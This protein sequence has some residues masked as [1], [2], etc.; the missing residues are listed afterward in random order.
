M[1]NISDRE[2][3]D[4]FKNESSRNN[5]FSQ[6]VT[7]Y[8]EKI[9]WHI[10]RMIIDHEDSNDVL[11][12]VFIK[13]WKGLGNFRED[14]QL[15]SWIYRIA[16]NECITFLKNKRKNLMISESEL[17]DVLSANMA[18]ST[19]IGA[20]EIEVKLQKAI[21]SLP[22]K[23]RIVFN[24]RYY[25]EMSYDE[26]SKVLKTSVGALKASYHIALKKVEKILTT[27]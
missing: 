14:S 2:I 27:D 5:A 7:K 24:L 23:Q 18:D 1:A 6:L 9:Y 4:S 17:G 16:T 11:Q 13:I 21:L 25:D 19:S 3:L 20:E 22:E 10:R 12:N 15:Y 8:Q 26:M